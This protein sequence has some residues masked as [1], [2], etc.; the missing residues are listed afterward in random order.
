MHMM[1][2]YSEFWD[3]VHFFFIQILA[4]DA[5]LSCHCLDR[6]QFLLYPSLP[7]GQSSMVT[8]QKVLNRAMVDL[9]PVGNRC[10][11]FLPIC[12]YLSCSQMLLLIFLNPNHSVNLLESLGQV[13]CRL[14]HSGTWI[15]V[16]L[17]FS[18]LAPPVTRGCIFKTSSSATNLGNLQ[19]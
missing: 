8:C 15:M 13:K 2:I 12:P 5:S 18:R 7:A 3:Q 1:R 10:P 9:S 14:V 6:Y 19:L 11:I 17:P 16:A 4:S